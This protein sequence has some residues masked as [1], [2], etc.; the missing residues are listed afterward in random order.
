MQV[1]TGPERFDEAHFK[2]PLELL[3]NTFPLLLKS[4]SPLKLSEE[5]PHE[6]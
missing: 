6:L 4:E 2:V 1:K 3:R 5:S